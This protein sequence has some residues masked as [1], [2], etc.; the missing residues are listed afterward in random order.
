MDENYGFNKKTHGLPNWAMPPILRTRAPVHQQRPGAP[1]EGGQGLRVAALH[2]EGAA[3]VVPPTQRRGAGR[4][5][6]SPRRKVTNNLGGLGET[7][8]T[9]KP[10][11]PKKHEKPNGWESPSLKL[12]AELRDC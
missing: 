12:L 8:K 1:G 6:G 3:P 5:I 9:C 11:N 10:I 4:F 2:A 7:T